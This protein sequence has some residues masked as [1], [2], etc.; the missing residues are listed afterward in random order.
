MLL[1][2]FILNSYTS[3]RKCQKPR[4][5]YQVKHLFTYSRS[6]ASFVTATSMYSIAPSASAE[7]LATMA[8]FVNFCSKTWAQ[9]L[10]PVT[11]FSIFFLKL[12]PQRFSK[13]NVIFKV[14]EF[15][16][17][18]Q[19]CSCRD[20]ISSWSLKIKIYKNSHSVCFAWLDI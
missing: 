12:L 19:K 1:F 14:K 2:V 7:L 20:Q 8:C 15:S 11:T 6:I 13:M 3:N 16:K 17:L 4:G 18:K 9:I 5:Q 10:T